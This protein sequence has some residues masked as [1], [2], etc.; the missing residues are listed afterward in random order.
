MKPIEGAESE[1]AL[2]FF[3][4]VGKGLVGAVTKPAV[5]FFDLASNLSE[6]VRNTTTVFDRPARER[7]R[8]PRHVPQDGVL[9]PFSERSALG[10]YW[11]KDLDNGAYRQEF[12][13][14]HINLPGGDGVTLLAADR[15]LTF[16]TKKL[17]LDWD[18]PLAQVLRVINEDHGIRFAHKAG[19]D[20]DRYVV[21][22]DQKSQA[23]LYEQI[24]GVVKSFNARRRMDS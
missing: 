22:E 10:Q 17:R 4:G 11:L 2:G 8:L 7:V 21:I 14:A 20:R 15:I 3:K 16:G 18:L 5:G 13:V 12:Y 1:G 6:G 19:K 23:W 24:A 9:M